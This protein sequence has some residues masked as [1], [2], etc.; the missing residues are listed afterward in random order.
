MP[1]TNKLETHQNILSDI[2]PPN[3]WFTEEDIR[4][5]P[6]KA[7]NTTQEFITYIDNTLPQA[8]KKSEDLMDQ[9]AAQ[10]DI[11]VKVAYLTVDVDATYHIFLLVSLHDFHSPHMQAAKLLVEKFTDNSLD[12]SI[13]FTFTVDREQFMSYAAPDRFKLKHVRSIER[14]AN[15]F[16]DNKI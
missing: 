9:L 5:S 10:Q 3:G 12:L 7:Y 6:N 1:N 13:R 4:N 15:P 8:T 16:S 14:G 11:M 2:T